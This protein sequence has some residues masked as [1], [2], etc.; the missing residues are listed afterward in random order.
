[1]KKTKILLSVFVV[2]MFVVTNCG[3]D[4]TLPDMEE[5]GYPREV[6]FTEYF[7]SDGPFMGCYYQPLHESR[8]QWKA[9]LGSDCG[10]IIINS[11]EEM[12]NYIECKE[13]NYPTID[14][15]KYTLLLA[16]GIS[17]DVWKREISLQ[18][19]SVRSYLMEIDLSI[20]LTQV[21]RCWRVPIIV[22]RIEDGST[23]ELIVTPVQTGG[24]LCE[25]K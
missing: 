21:I 10:A 17:G 11:N 7:L 12:E 6:P 3:D 20:S 5:I 2:L 23:V 18:Q 15:S 1:V 24:G 16:H 22:D 19:L 14:F 9:D 25:R 4:G 13:V 8:C